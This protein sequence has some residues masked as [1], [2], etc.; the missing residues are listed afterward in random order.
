MTLLIK[1]ATKIPCDG[2]WFAVPRFGSLRSFRFQS[3]SSLVPV[4]FRLPAPAIISPDRPGLGLGL[5]LGNRHVSRATVSNRD[6]AVPLP[7]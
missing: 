5:G 3:G 6:M 2:P 7:N 4:R 1:L